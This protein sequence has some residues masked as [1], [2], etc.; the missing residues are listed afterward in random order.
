[1][2]SRPE[3]YLAAGLQGIQAKSN[4]GILRVAHANDSSA[5]YLCGLS[6]STTCQT[7]LVWRV[8]TIV[9]HRFLTAYRTAVNEQDG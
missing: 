6:A 8:E 4:R 1:M 7:E 2:Q 3:N 9:P 5:E